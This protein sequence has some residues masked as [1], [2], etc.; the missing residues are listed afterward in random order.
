MAASTETVKH[1]PGPWRFEREG[2]DSYSVRPG[3]TGGLVA[4]VTESILW[5]DAPQV[6]E[7]NARLIAAAPD[8]LAELEDLVG[9]AEAAMRAA[10]RDG[11]EYDIEAELANA[12]DLV[13]RAKGQ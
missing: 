1:Y 9:L 4:H 3:T 10:N 8:L 12:R 11:S 5:Y 13:K 2:K 7:A 6:T